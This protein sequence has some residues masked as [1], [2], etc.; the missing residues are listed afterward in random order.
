M[1]VYA[2]ILAGG[3]GTRLWPRS[4]RRQPKHLLALEHGTAPLLRQTY[5]RI[6][7]LVDDVYVVTEEHQVE[8]ILEVLPE[9]ARDHVIVEPVARGT[10]S[11]LGLA[12][13]SLRR[14]DPDAVMLSLPADH[15]IGDS[16]RF[17]QT[18]RRV[19]RLE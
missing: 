7:T 3:S 12:A 4:R 11:A 13:M 9:I 6:H 14:R 19:V 10:T 8:S 16:R 2:T 5:E 17:K 1:G 15:I 18:I